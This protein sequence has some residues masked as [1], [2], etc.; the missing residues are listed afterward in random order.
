[1]VFKCI[2]ERLLVDKL[3]I[4]VNRMYTYILMLEIAGRHRCHMFYINWLNSRSTRFFELTREPNLV[5][6][7][8]LTKCIFS[9]N[10][11]INGFF[12]HNNQSTISCAFWIL[13]WRIQCVFH[14]HV[15]QISLSN[16]YP[17]FNFQQCS[18]QRASVIQFFIRWTYITFE[19]LNL[20]FT[21][22]FV[23]FCMNIE[24]TFY[25]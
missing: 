15:K 25:I 3:N 6:C 4:S 12:C 19:R 1:M 11:S 16:Y 23:R 5:W 2:K 18:E 7:E 10:K 17:S 20:L 24:M 22:H 9:K 21:E 13:F 8:S 14:F